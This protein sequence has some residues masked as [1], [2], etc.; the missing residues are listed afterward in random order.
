MKLN[1]QYKMMNALIDDLKKAGLYNELKAK[2]LRA[3]ADIRN[4][5]AHGEFDEFDRKDTEEMLKGVQNFLA[6]YM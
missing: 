3:W 5:A 1:G 4:A 6:D 2:R